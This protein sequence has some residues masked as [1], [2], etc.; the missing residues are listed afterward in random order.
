[1]SERI[2]VGDLVVVFKPAVCCA[3]GV[4][5]I[6][7]VT[8]IRPRKVV[9]GIPHKSKCQHCG[10]TTIYTPTG[11]EDKVADGLFYKPKRGV[12]VSRL[13]RIPPLE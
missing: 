6:F 8:N 13:K 5:K 2:A 3:A 9:I 10:H 11:R 1:M 7:K 4:G 12:P